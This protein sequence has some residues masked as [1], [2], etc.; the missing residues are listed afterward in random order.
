MKKFLPVYEKFCED[1][2]EVDHLCVWFCVGNS[3]KKIFHR[4]IELY[5]RLSLKP[6]NNLGPERL[7]NGALKQEM[8]NGVKTQKEHLSSVLI[9]M[10]RKKRLHGMNLWINLKAKAWNF[11]SRMVLYGVLYMVAQ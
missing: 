10:L 2:N 9:L 8:L 6:C 7:N 11:V 4:N 1:E 5:I 3:K